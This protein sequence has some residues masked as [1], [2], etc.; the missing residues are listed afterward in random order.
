MAIKGES[1]GN[2]RHDVSISERQCGRALPFE[3]W[4]EALNKDYALGCRSH[5]DAVFA[6]GI[7]IG[8]AGAL[9]IA[10][11]WMSGQTLQP[12]GRQHAEED[13]LMVKMIVEGEAVFE[14][15]GEQCRFGAGG[16]V[17]VDPAQPFLEH[18][19]AHAKLLV[20]SAPK[21]ALRERG[22]KYSINRWVAPDITSPDVRLVQDM[23]RLIAS[24]SPALDQDMR[25]RLGYQLLD[26][27]DVVLRQDLNPPAEAVR[28]RVKHYVAQ[29]LGDATL[30]TARIAAAVNLSTG[31]LNRLFAGEDMSLMRYVWTRRLDLAQQML[32][33]PRWR[34]Q[35][36]EAIAWRC[37]F[38]SP[39]HFS[40][41]FKEH[42]GTTPRQM[43][44]APLS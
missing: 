14:R 8:Q 13:V 34:G 10:D 5:R 27:M 23:V 31:H 21:D 41:L 19:P 25:A 40:R 33:A 28:L 35:S 44:A 36:I 39:A 22:Y 26:L 7:S 9:K 17:I 16:M 12:N 3:I 24:H 6:S 18:V 15:D 29:N 4:Q 32:A 11:V 42:Y 38:V 20:V 2:N 30:D 1:V 43:R 37:G